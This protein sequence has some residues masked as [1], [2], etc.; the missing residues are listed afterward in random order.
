M[1]DNTG[2]R[3]LRALG[4]V[5]IF[6]FAVSATLGSI[7]WLLGAPVVMSYVATGLIGLGVGAFLCIISEGERIE[8]QS[9][10]NIDS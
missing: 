9:R 3:F 1:K 4:V 7:L 5:S 10:K 8:R 6:G 2:N